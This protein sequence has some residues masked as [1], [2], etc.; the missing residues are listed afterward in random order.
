MLRQTLTLVPAHSQQL[1]QRGMATLKSIS[2]RLK[3]VKNIQ[4]IT[5]SMKMVSAAKYNRAERDLKQAR[6]LGEGTKAFYEKA[7]IAAPEGV[8]SKLVIAITSDRGLCGACHT[9][10]ARNIRDQL[11]A[12]PADKENT[13]IICVGEKSR[14]V[15]ARIFANNIL[16]VASEV[17]RLPPTFTDASKLAAEI[18]NSGYSFASGRIVYNK[19]KSVVS[20]GVADLPL[21]DK[22]SVATAPKLSIYDSLDDSVIQSYLEFS[23]A[24][25]LFYSMKEGA[26]SEQSSRMTAMDNASKNAGEMIEK[27]TL[28]FN[29]TRQAVITRELIEIISGAAALD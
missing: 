28:T 25:L 9:G 13:K 21:Y 6:P 19:F 1:Q 2:L 4:K 29:R 26:C 7:E 3:S 15:L 20:Y 5:Q 23:L 18:L 8:P 11:L 24:S 27:L 14:A 22:D 17:G 12:N 16:F 10:V